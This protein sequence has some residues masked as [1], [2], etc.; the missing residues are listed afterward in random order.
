MK[1]ADDITQLIGHTPLVWLNR[2]TEGGRAP[3]AANRIGVSMI[4]EAERA[5]NISP[6]RTVLIEP[7]SG[8]TG[9]GTGVRRGSKGLQADS[10]HAGHYEPGTP[11]SAAGVR[12]GDSPDTRN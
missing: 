1:I 3:I 12:R 9:I 11:C 8:N 6:G 7:T 10:D 5:G 4:V 2:V